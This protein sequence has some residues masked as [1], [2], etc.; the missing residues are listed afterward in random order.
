MNIIRRLSKKVGQL[1]IEKIVKE[2]ALA[3]SAFL[4]RLNQTQLQASEDSEGRKLVS[5]RAS[6][7]RVSK[8]EQL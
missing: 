1:N 4:I 6:L 5:M 7:T 3:D 2:E 8:G